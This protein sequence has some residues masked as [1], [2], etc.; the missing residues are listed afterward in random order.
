[1]TN[2]PTIKI[3]SIT[4]LLLHEGDRL[5]LIGANL[6][7]ANLIGANLTDA[8]LRDANLGGADL[9]GADLIGA[10]VDDSGSLLVGTRP[11]IVV[12]PIGSRSDYCTGFITDHGLRIRAGCFY[13]SVDEFELA[14]RKTHGKKCHAIEYA[15]A[16]SFIRTH[17]AIWTPAPLR[18]EST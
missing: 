16:V 3:Y 10:T 5:N 6:R 4:G 7:D 11:I 15:A 12:G 17:A 2:K 14:V 8:D 13:D 18:Q 1:M 9:G